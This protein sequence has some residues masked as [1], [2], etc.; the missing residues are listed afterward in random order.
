MENIFLYSDTIRQFFDNE[1]IKE[2]FE[3]K[4]ENCPVCGSGNSKLLFIQY[5]FRYERCNGCSFVFVNPRLNDIGSF[6]WY[7]SNYYN[8]ALETEY[9][10]ILNG[11]RY[12]SSLDEV[13]FSKAAFLIKKEL[14][15]KDSSI[16][17]IGS[18]NGAFIEYLKV[19]EGFENVTGIDL[20][21]R[22]AAFARDFR[23]LNV[24]NINVSELQTDKKFD[25]IISMESIEH[26]AE[27]DKF[28]KQVK[29]FSK[30]TSCLLITTP[31][32]DSKATAIGGVWGDHYM[33]PNHINFFNFKSM[34]SF[35][36]KH[37][38]RIRHYEIPEN[39]LGKDLLT[40]KMK[41]K[42]DWAVS[43]PPVMVENV[44][45]VPKNEPDNS[46]YVR[47]IDPESSGD[48]Q[49]GRSGY[50]F[51]K[52]IYHKV[53]DIFNFKWKYHFIILA[54]KIKS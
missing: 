11:N 8:A 5:G 39:Y 12:A 15:S 41:Y 23:K 45:A 27:L 14:H 13:M 43:V 37:G 16:L 36:K 30:E 22:A 49:N 34:N 29:R 6:L 46:R 54:Q 38:F 50:N 53:S 3:L 35:L 26:I 25:L 7:N 33:A 32:N 1:M 9:F 42:R 44:M 20:N 47:F 18:G 24:M 4:L 2:E 19:K 51:L 28:M 40:H 10:K 48:V 52:N 17:E 31:Y 21:K